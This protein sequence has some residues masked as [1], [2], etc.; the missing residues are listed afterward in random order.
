[1]SGKV[2]KPKEDKDASKGKRRALPCTDCLTPKSVFFPLNATM[3]PFISY[4]VLKSSFEVRLKTI[5]ATRWWAIPSMVHV[6]FIVFRSKLS[7]CCCRP[8]CCTMCRFLITRFTCTDLVI[9]KK[10]ESTRQKRR[11]NRLREAGQEATVSQTVNK[12]RL[13]T[14]RKHIKLKSW[15]WF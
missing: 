12:N 4:T 2:A 14:K 10:R 3:R 1:M 9:V 13:Y 7:D 6:S 15:Q 8:V 11:I 5:A